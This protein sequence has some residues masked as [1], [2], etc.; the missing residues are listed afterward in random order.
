MNRTHVMTA[1]VALGTLIWAPLRAGADEVTEDAAL[2]L[3]EEHHLTG[4]LSPRLPEARVRAGGF[5]GYDSARRSAVVGASAEVGLTRWLSMRAGF[6]YVPQDALNATARPNLALRAQ[7]LGQAGVGVDASVALAYRQERFAEDGGLLEAAL[8]VGRTDGRLSTLANVAY[9]QDPEGDDHEAE[10][11]AAALYR[12]ATSIG[13]G[14]Q[15]NLRRDLGSTDARR[16]TRIQPDSELTAGPVASYNV[17][18]WVALVHAGVS[19]MSTGSGS[20]KDGARH[21]GAF[22]LAALGAGF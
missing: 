17:G 18:P 12:V 8:S 22:G 15:A 21:T 14:V 13:L 1:L 20:M 6:V 19:T 3:P 10:L 2:Q 7:V 5:G 4:I 16:A 11:R 9:A